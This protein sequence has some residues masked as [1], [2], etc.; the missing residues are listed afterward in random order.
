MNS[1][2]RGFEL[3]SLGCATPPTTIGD[4]CY[5]PMDSLEISLFYKTDACY[6]YGYDVPINETCENDYAAVIY[7]NPYYF[8][9]SYDNPLLIFMIMRSVA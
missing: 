6:A 7:D 2:R 4:E 3:R 9:K 5:V 8:Y 1:P